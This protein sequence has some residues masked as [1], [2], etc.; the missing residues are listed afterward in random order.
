MGRPSRAATALL[1]ALGG[2]SVAAAQHLQLPALQFG[3]ADL[4][5]YIDEATMEVHHLGHMQAYTDKA[6]A[7]LAELRANATTNALAKLGLD[8][9]LSRLGD[10]P[11]P[12]RSALRNHGG[13][14]VNHELFF[15]SLGVPEEKGGPG[16]RFLPGTPLG[17][18]IAR[19]FVSFAIFQELF[20]QAALR[21]FGSGWVWLELDKRG[22]DNAVGVL[23]IT[24]TPN[25]DSLTMDSPLRVPLLGLDVWEHAYC[26]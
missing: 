10:V 5:P 1:A 12:Q 19:Q 16:G 2:A 15:A 18:A 25:Q 3:Y 21:V 8:A 11:E 22:G 6:N 20:R 26:E 4:E 13:G 7:A 14:Y 9:L 17:Q 24:T 23:A